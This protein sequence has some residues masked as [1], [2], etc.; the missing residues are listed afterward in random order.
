MRRK[1][2]GQY[3][4]SSEVPPRDELGSFHIQRSALCLDFPMMQFELN[5]VFSASKSRQDHCSHKYTLHL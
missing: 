1:S 4:F 3:F 2:A 5:A